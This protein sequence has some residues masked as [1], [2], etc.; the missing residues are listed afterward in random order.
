MKNKQ[1]PA[2][3]ADL[4]SK[5]MADARKFTNELNSAKNPNPKAVECLRKFAV[6]TPGFLS[7]NSIM[8]IGSGTAS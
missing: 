8:G 5:L 3:T 1:L 6:Q 2:A 4:R 7:A